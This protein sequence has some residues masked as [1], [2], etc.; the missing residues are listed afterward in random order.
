MGCA[1]YSDIFGG[2]AECVERAFAKVELQ[3]NLRNLYTDLAEHTQATIYLMQYPLTV[4]SVAIAYT[5]TQIAQMGQLLDREIAK[6]AAE[7][8][9]RRLQVVAPPHFNV[10]VSVE[11]VYPSNYSCSRLGYRTCSG[12]RACCAF[13]CRERLSR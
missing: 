13:R 10:G 1:I 9:P 2:F 6:V 4:P 5:S 8:N 3:T 11:P 12:L 7:V